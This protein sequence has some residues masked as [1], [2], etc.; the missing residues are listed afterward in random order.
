MIGIRLGKSYKLDWFGSS[1]A[2]IKI[3]IWFKIDQKAGE[4][5]IQ[6]L[7]KV[8]RVAEIIFVVRFMC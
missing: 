5:Y 7:K 6:I 8:V 2:L 1:D 4:E 3:Q